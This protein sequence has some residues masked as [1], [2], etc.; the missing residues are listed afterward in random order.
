MA[1]E[2]ENPEWNIQNH[3]AHKII[4]KY[5]VGFG[6]WVKWLVFL[7]DIQSGGYLI[8]QDNLSP[9]TWKGLALLR[10]WQ[11]KQNDPFKEILNIK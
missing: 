4:Q 11:E 5:P 6:E 3:P 2:T 10:Q 9:L 7:R 8:D 1:Y